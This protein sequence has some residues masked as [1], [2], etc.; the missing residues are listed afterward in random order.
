MISCLFPYE[1]L[2]CD[3]FIEVFASTLWIQCHFTSCVFVLIMWSLCFRTIW[4]GF[5]PPCCAINVRMFLYCTNMP[6]WFKL[7]IAA[8]RFFKAAEFR[9]QHIW[10]C[11][12][13]WAE[14]SEQVCDTGSFYV[15]AG[16]DPEQRA[17]FNHR[18]STEQ[19]NWWRRWNLRGTED[20][21]I[22]HRLSSVWWRV[23]VRRF[24]WWLESV[25]SVITPEPE[26]KWR[27]DWNSGEC[28]VERQAFQD[29]CCRANRFFWTFGVREQ[30][31]VPAALPVFH[32]HTFSS[33]LWC[34]MRFLSAPLIVRRDEVRTAPHLT[35]SP[36]ESSVDIFNDILEFVTSWKIIRLLMTHPALGG[37]SVNYLSNQCFLYFVKKKSS[38][39]SGPENTPK[40]PGP[41]VEVADPDTN[42]SSGRHVDRSFLW[43]AAG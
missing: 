38:S 1:V 42:Q 23:E 21:M 34:M 14:V 31:A 28:F 20:K 30:W 10:I 32:L 9:E 35:Y 41:P 40:L 39:R 2:S 26:S 24:W 3:R 5:C 43:G 17:C 27:T 13:N 12:S 7:D 25:S 11:W 29:N 33:L 16:S 36:S 6:T 8:H 37:V 15:G 18:R 19:R 4:S 22:P